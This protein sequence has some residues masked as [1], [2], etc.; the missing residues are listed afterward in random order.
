MVLSVLPVKAPSY[1][2]AVRY[3]RLLPA[4]DVTEILLTHVVTPPPCNHVDFRK[5]GRLAHVDVHT[6]Q[7]R[8]LLA[9]VQAIENIT[10]Q[11]DEPNGFPI[12]KEQESAPSYL[13]LRGEC[14]AAC[15]R[16]LRGGYAEQ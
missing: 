11:V 4:C 15:C 13:N 3:D 7:I 6:R 16:F 12:C 5:I 14:V 2:R 10:V 9:E 1:I 8:D